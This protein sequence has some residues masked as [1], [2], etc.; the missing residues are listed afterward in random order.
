ME[1]KKVNIKPLFEACGMNVGNLEIIETSGMYPYKNVIEENWAYFT[2]VG[3]KQLKE[4]FKKENK[5]ITEVGIVG[6]CS[7]VEG[8]AVAHIFGDNLKRL[9]VTD[10]D[11]GILDGTIT[12][13]KGATPNLNYELVPLVGLFCEPIE[14]AGY[15]VDFVH[16]NIPNLPTTGE[17]DLSKGDEKG[18]F[19]PPEYYEKYQPKVEF[20]HWALAAQYA[21]LQS[22]KKVLKPGGSVIAELGG[23]IPFSLIE[24][25]F[26]SCDLELQEVIVGF[27]EQTEALI[28][29][30]GYHQNEVQFGVAFEYYLY[31]EGK[32]IFEKNNLQNPN[33]EISGKELKQLLEPYKLTAG[34]A[35]DAYKKG[36]KIGHVVHL[37]R[38][39]KK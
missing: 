20:I 21:Y 33:Y 35:I 23:R 8:I 7:G 36:I 34:Q 22:A 18:S 1:G 4:L 13:I 6:I 32:E 11:Q 9:I 12:N 24:D 38:G 5:E 14:D 31:K 15:K 27:K 17:E 26:A 28:N 39:V 16:A 10:I 30:A 3:C 2:T 19:A 25:L 37:L 29:F